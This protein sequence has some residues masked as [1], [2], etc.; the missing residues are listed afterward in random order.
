MAMTTTLLT[1]MSK[2]EWSVKLKDHRNSNSTLR[3]TVNDMFLQIFVQAQCRARSWTL[4]K[5]AIES[6]RKANRVIV[7]SRVQRGKVPHA[8]WFVSPSQIDSISFNKKFSVFSTFPPISSVIRSLT[9]QVSQARSWS[10]S[11]QQTFN[12]SDATK[13]FDL[14]AVLSCLGQ[15]SERETIEKCERRRRRARHDRHERN[16]QKSREKMLC[17]VW[18]SSWIRGNGVKSMEKS[19]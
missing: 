10:V 17:N 3:S 8:A 1:L 2:R 4:E 19:R 15:E 5:T 6:A 13:L 18:E 11:V 9:R 16:A 14:F 7:S 12:S